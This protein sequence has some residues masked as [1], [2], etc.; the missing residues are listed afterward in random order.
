[1]SRHAII[2][3]AGIGGLTAAVALRRRGWDV[4]VLDRARALESVGAGLGLGPNALHALDAI[5]L[6][7]EVRRFSAI[8]GHGGLRRPGGGWLVRTDLGGLAARFGDP[9]LVALRADVV[10]L[11]AGRLPAGMLR[12]GVT[13][14]GVDAGDADRRACVATSAGDLDADLV[15]AADGIGSRIRAALFPDYPGPRY[16]GFT[17][18]RFVTPAVPEGAGQAEPAETWG[19]GEV[20]GVLPLASGQVYCYASAPAPAGVRHDD[21][22]AEL[23]QRFGRW[24]DPIPGLIGA[25]SPDRVLHDDVY[26]MAESLPAYHR[27]RVAILGDA[28]HAMTPHLGQGACQAIE[29]AVVL[30]C[31][32]G[33][34]TPAE[35]A[36]DLAAYTTA[37]LPR[38]RMV[39]NGSY[40]AT[41]LSGMT[42]R[43]VI[44]VRNSGI[45]LAGR[46]APGLMLRQMDPIA[47]W[48]PPL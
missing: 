6:G 13:V 25:I 40:R 42:S 5:G 44:A 17:T 41:R 30:A 21:E 10:D 1:M 8:Q 35:T 36:P 28:A 23:K 43:P 33:P 38:T 4:T 2:A 31:V 34:G 45:R 26:W 3:G 37:R 7:D 29:D 19:R 9:Q 18:W 11:L 47:S 39:A 46:L 48:T 16:S 20:F 24:H 12:T 27:G 15:V 14:T 22:A 32:A